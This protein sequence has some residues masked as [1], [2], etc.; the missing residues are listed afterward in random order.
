MV[1]QQT[2]FES[3]LVSCVIPVYNRS[4]MIRRSVDS[5][6]NQTYSNFEIILVDDGSNDFTPQVLEELKVKHPNIIQVAYQENAGP[7]VAR[8]TGL[9]L[10]KGEYVQY[11]DSD[12]IIYP[13]KFEKQVETLKS[14]PQAGVCYCTTLRTNR[15]NELVPWAKT[16]LKIENLFPGFLMKRSWATLT[17]LWRR[18]VCEQI[19]EW[20]SLRVMEDWEHDLRAGLMGIQPVG[21][22]I[23]LAEVCDHDEERAS[24]MG[25][26]FTVPLTKDFFL[27]HQSIYLKMKER[28]L[29]NWSYLE[30]F[31]R[32]MFWISRMCGERGLIDE[33]N[34]AIDYAEEMI[35]THH[36]P[37]EIR[38][39]RL[40]KNILGWK[41]SVAISEK[42]RKLIRSLRSKKGVSA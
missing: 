23:E 34:S 27:A 25:T 28:D 17:P 12:D 1:D 2:Q 19:G 3:G 32:K 24:G 42:S 8:N 41:W 33:A 36:S 14:N 10:A 29:L 15:E 30:E 20:S 13:E 26:G 9:K 35:R 31:S 37:K 7:G 39:F 38:Y 16:A 6:L 11:L 18:S 22:L 40:L 5:V 21:C 4:E